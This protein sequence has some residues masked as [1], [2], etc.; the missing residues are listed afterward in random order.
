MWWF[1][2][3]LCWLV[4]VKFTLKFIGYCAAMREAGDKAAEEYFKRND[5]NAN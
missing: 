1:V 3:I 5:N 4:V 2:G